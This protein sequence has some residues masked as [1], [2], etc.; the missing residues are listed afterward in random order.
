MAPYLCL[1][2]YNAAAFKDMT[3]EDMRKIGAFCAPHDE[4]LKTS[5]KVVCMGSLGMQD[6]VKTITGGQHARVRDGPY[7]RTDTHLGALFMVEAESMEEAV[8]I[9]K[10]HPGAHIDP[11]WL[12]GA[13]EVWPI[14]EWEVDGTFSSTVPPAL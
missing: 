5:G 6:Q 9:A 11:E 13:I 8:A 2:F 12:E 1:W 7:V 4:R 10:L 3:S 14:G